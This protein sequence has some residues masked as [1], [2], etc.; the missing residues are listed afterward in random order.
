MSGPI[1]A[2]PTADVWRG[3][4]SYSS[5]GKTWE[6]ALKGLPEGAGSMCGEYVCVTEEDAGGRKIICPPSAANGKPGEACFAQKFA[7]ATLDRFIRLTT[8]KLLCE[9]DEKKSDKGC[10]QGLGLVQ[11]V[12]ALKKRKMPLP[13]EVNSPFLVNAYYSPRDL[14]LVFGDGEKKFLLA[15]DGDIIVHEAAHWLIDTINPALGSSWRGLGNAIHEGSADAMAALHFGDPQMAEDFNFYKVGRGYK[16]GLRTVKNTRTVANLKL[17]EPH[18]MG[19]IIGGFWWSLYER[20]VVS[21]KKANPSAYKENPALF[22]QLAR[23]ATM[24]LVLAHAG[25]Y[26]VPSP[27]APDFLEAVSRAATDLNFIDGLTELTKRGVGLMAILKEIAAEG[28][29]RGLGEPIWP[30]SWHGNTGK[31]SAISFGP[32]LSITGAAGESIAY[33]PQTHMT[34]QGPALVLGYG[35]IERDGR[36]D[37]KGLREIGEGEIDETVVFSRGEAYKRAVSA[38]G[39]ELADLLASRKDDA[40]IPAASRKQI[41]SKA[42]KT[43]ESTGFSEGKLAILPGEKG[44]AWLF[45]AGVAEI[46]VDAKTGKVKILVKGLID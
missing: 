39:K 32:A 27:D 19:K 3:E 26:S 24:K 33:K 44:L 13:V 31:K 28:D 42:R 15:T 30:M 1:K 29:A 22:E 36:S 37:A 41:L 43:L 34:S 18:E 46:A 11:V 40:E 7:Y 25:S 35:A 4:N 23:N 2:G 17:T 14:K 8:D 10:A 12:E 20:L 16:G 9:L 5:D 21:L 45:D 6:V 38:A